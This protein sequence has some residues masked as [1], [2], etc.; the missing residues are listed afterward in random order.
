M[1]DDVIAT[2]R[3]L[4]A[5]AQQAVGVA[6]DLDPVPGLLSCKVARGTA[7]FTARP[8]GHRPRG[9]SRWGCCQAALPRSVLVC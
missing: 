3:P 5:A 1:L 7:D 8:A 9:E 4:D 2:I 6:A